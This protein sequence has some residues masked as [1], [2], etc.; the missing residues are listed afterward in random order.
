MLET[1]IPR[2]HLPLLALVCLANAVNIVFNVKNKCSLALALP[3]GKEMRLA[4][5]ET[6]TELYL[7]L[8]QEGSI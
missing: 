8:R 3:V 1:F 5:V 4:L 6:L 7:G 2:F